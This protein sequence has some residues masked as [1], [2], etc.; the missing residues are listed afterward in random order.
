MAYSAPLEGS[1]EKVSKPGTA[2]YFPPFSPSLMSGP[3][4]ITKEAVATLKQGGM[5][6]KYS[7]IPVTQ[8]VA[9]ASALLII[10]VATLEGLEW[11]ISRIRKPSQINLLSESLKQGMNIISHQFQVPIPFMLKMIS[12]STLKFF[13]NAAP[14]LLPFEL[15]PFL[16]AHFNKVSTQTRMLMED[17]IK[18]GVQAG[19]PTEA[20]KRIENEVGAHKR[21]KV[22]SRPRT[23]EKT[24]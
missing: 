20:L 11:S 17:Y 10:S 2:F 5:A 21:P 13:L 16:K 8:S 9:F 19:L 18:L 6:S 23:N 4:A 7:D 24:L 12:P 22:D 3:H 1:Q 15:E 14:Q